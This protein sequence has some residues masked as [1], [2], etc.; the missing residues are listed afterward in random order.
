MARGRQRHVLHED[1]LPP[2]RLSVAPGPAALGDPRFRR[3]L[4]P[5]DWARL[6]AAVRA[7]FSKRLR[8][9]ESASYDGVI[10]ECAISRAGRVLAQGCRVIGAPLPLEATQGLAAVVSVTEDGAG[11]GQIWTRVYA[12]ARAFPQVIHSAKRFAGPTGL[13]EHIGRGFGIALRVEAMGQ[14]I[15]FVSDHYFV[16][17][18]PLRL[19]LPRWLAPGRLSIEHRDIGCGRFLFTLELAHSLLGALVRQQGLFRDRLPLP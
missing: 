17:A 15:R 7:R 16:E 10:T 2:A 8:G 1:V 13:E 3:L 4:E 6:P 5:A 14:G 19:R 12:R 9:G 18:G 11:G